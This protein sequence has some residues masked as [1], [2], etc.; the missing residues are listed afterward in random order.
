M[1]RAPA[2][3][4]K[5]TAPSSGARR[6]RRF[7]EERAL[8]VRERRA[9][10]TRA[11][12]G[13]S[14]SIAAVGERREVVGRARESDANAARPGSYGSETCDVGAPGERLEQRP[15]GAGQI[16]EPVG[17]H[18]LAVPRVEVGL[19]PLGGAAAQEVAIPEPEPVELGAVGGVERARGRRRA[20]SGSSRPDSSSP[21]PAAASRRSRRCAAD[22]REPVRAPPP[23]RTRRTTS[24][25]CARSRPDAR[26]GSP[27]ASRSK[28]SSN[29]PISP[30]EQAAR[31]REQV[32]LDAVDVRPVR[33]DQ[34]RLVV[35][36]RQIALQQER[37]LARVCRP[38]EEATVPPSHRRVAAGR[39]RAARTTVFRSYA[40]DRF[41]R[42]PRRAAARPGSRPG[43][44]VAEVGDLRAAARVA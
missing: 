22:A 11:E 31:A 35:E 8:E 41:G 3:S 6:R 9:R 44:V 20:R 18:R 27:R 39:V 28:R 30:A 43:A 19:E 36:A 7:L 34:K 2:P 12:R 32:A 25:R 38:R 23:R 13:G 42:R 26:R 21:R 33:H 40:A 29:V 5:R 10:R 15:L 37:D 1:P 24:A 4:R 14:S 17:E 16:L